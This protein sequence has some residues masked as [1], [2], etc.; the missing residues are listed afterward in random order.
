M[1]YKEA[2]SSPISSPRLDLMLCMGDSHPIH[3]VA[4][5]PSTWGDTITSTCGPHVATTH[6]TL[7]PSQ[8]V[9]RHPS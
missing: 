4:V 1:A 2:F 6:A 9:T 7:S 5:T 8:S 3:V